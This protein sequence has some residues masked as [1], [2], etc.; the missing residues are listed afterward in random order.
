MTRL[1]SKRGT[2]TR[3]L[4]LPVTPDVVALEQADL[5]RREFQ[6]TLPPDTHRAVQEKRDAAQMMRM[7]SRGAFATEEAL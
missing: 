5:D 3:L 7:I 2:C 6:L 1:V 4:R